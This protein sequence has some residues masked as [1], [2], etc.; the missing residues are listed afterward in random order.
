MIEF[1]IYRLGIAG[2]LNK[3]PGIQFEGNTDLKSL[4]TFLKDHPADILLVNTR[5]KSI[6]NRSYYAEARKAFRN[7]KFIF[8]LNN[9][10]E[11]EIRQYR[12]FELNGLLLKSLDISELE[13]A[14]R[15]VYKTG[16]YFSQ[17][18]PEELLEDFLEKNKYAHHKDLFHLTN[19][20]YQIMMMIYHEFSTHEIA[21]QLDISRRTVEGHRLKILRKIGVRNNIGI[22]KFVARN[23]L[24]F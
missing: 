20:E 14:I 1:P 11:E 24:S 18:I 23:V 2:V 6:F 4:K 12:G 15:T 10:L 16:S 17:G 8:F 21:A 13:Y 22:V 5:K 19:R 9:G 7:L 3:L